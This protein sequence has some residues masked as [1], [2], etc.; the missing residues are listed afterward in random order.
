MQHRIDTSLIARASRDGGW[1]LAAMRLH[2]AMAE[3]GDVGV[4]RDAGSAPAV[5]EV[6]VPDDGTGRAH[7]AALP[8]HLTSFVGRAAELAEITRM[9]EVSALVT[10]TGTGGVGKTR[11][12]LR[13]ASG[14]SDA[15]PDGV[16]F[17]DLAPLAPRADPALVVSVVLATVGAAEAP[18]Q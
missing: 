15:Y 8:R 9:L 2:F 4:T 16:W 5:R 3:S 1:C 18:G 12:A 17:V 13:A 7:T 11:L 14:V 10:L 6:T